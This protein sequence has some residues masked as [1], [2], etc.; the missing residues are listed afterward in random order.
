MNER[1]AAGFVYDPVCDNNRRHHP[2]LVEWEDLSEQ[3]KSKDTDTITYLPQLLESAGLFITR[4]SNQ[5][6]RRP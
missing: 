1:L 3:S 6:D 4:I 5:C 2:D